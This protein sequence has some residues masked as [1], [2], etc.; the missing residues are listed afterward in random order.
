MKNLTLIAL[1]FLGLSAQAQTK[2]TADKAYE[3]EKEKMSDGW[4]PSLKV[5]ANFQ[6]STNEDVIGQPNGETITLG[7]S[8]DGGLKYFLGNHEWRNS[9]TISEAYST[10]PTITGYIKNSDELK[11]DSLYL[12]SF[13]GMDWLGPYA[14]F[15]LATNIFFGEDVRTADT[16]VYNDEN[17]LVHTGSQLKTTNGFSP[18]TLKESVGFFAKALQEKN[19]QLE[20]RLGFGAQQVIVSTDRTQYAVESYD[21][22]TGTVTLKTLNDYS[23]A[24]LEAGALYTGNID[25][26]TSY[27]LSLELLTPFIN[28]DAQKRDAIELTNIEFLG[29]LNSKVY[30]W[31]S[32]TYEL[33]VKKQPQLLDDFQI[34]QMFLLNFNYTLL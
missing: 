16:T 7:T 11:L 17:G 10:N 9:L 21:A 30:E 24:G 27:K 2:L 20:F 23:E 22:G 18:I 33:K 15:Q 5:S 8:V 4:H 32:L 31:L 26:K 6:Y 29:A 34:Q 1:V 12:Y 28:S 19:Q 25:E 3:S 13:D 14:R